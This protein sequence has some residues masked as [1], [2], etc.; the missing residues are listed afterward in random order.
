MDKDKNST[1]ELARSVLTVEAEE[2]LNAKSNIN[3]DFDL[4][5]QKILKCDGRLILSGMGK[6][7]HIARKI[8]STFSSTGT[9]SFF[10]HPAKQA[11]VILV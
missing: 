4:A 2:I 1:I 11:M 8:S 7:G 9:P 3:S 10:M 6:S 5:V